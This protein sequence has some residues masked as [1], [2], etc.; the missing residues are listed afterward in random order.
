M[1]IEKIDSNKNCVEE[2][3]DAYHSVVKYLEQV[4]TL[5]NQATTRT[6]HTAPEIARKICVFQNCNR[7]FSTYLYMSNNIP[8]NVTKKSVAISAVVWRAF[9]IQSQHA[10]WS[11]LKKCIRYHS[12]N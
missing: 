9:P 10:F 1:S 4:S 2:F 12:S 3:E 6:S 11:F 5:F 8:N 7:F